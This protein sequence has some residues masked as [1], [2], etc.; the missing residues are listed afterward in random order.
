MSQFNEAHLTGFGYCLLTSLSALVVFL[1]LRL[2][3]CLPLYSSKKHRK[4]NTSAIIST[5]IFFGSGK[6]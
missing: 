2:S 6:V 4:L 5:L 3:I 1:L